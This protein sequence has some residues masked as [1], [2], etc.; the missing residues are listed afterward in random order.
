M[1]KAK[2]L[3]LLREKNGL[4]LKYR[5]FENDDITDIE[6]Y[7]ENILTNKEI[8]ESLEKYKFNMNAV[9][10]EFKQKKGLNGKDFAFLNF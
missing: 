1:T 10:E 9:Y 8:E 4:N 2:E 5:E 7:Y 6:S 3:K